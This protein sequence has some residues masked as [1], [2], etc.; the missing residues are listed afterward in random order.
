MG[1]RSL[2]HKIKLFFDRRAEASIPYTEEAKQYGNAGE[3]EFLYL[4]RRELP[5]CKIK[6]NVLIR[7]GESNAEIDF[8]V[9]Y[10]DKLFAIE[11]KRWKGRLTELADGFLK[12]KT[13]PWTGETHLEYLKSPFKQ[14]GRAI[15]LLKKQ[16]PG[17]VWINAV[18][19]FENEGIGDISTFSDNVWFHDYRALANY[20]RSGGTPSFGAGAR[21]F[22]S[23][24]FAADRVY[25]KNQNDPRSGIIDRSTLRFTTDEGLLPVAQIASIRIYHHWCYDTLSLEMVDGQE[26]LLTCENGEIQMLENGSIRRYALCRIDRIELGGTLIR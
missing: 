26:L 9:L 8:L 11:V 6:R 18:V 13:D 14:L 21:D 20:I 12:E 22:F 1:I 17:K 24:C 10:E 25:P 23:K 7:A 5:S 19:F 15:S 16:I 2:F 4:L 3:D